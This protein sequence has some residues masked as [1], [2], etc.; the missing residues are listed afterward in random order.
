MQIF[1]GEGADSNRYENQ[2]RD[3]EVAAAWR[4][5]RKRG[6]LGFMGETKQL[7]MYQ[8]KRP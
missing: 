8:K 5:S 2:L 6:Q 1:L 3:R 7:L 4:L